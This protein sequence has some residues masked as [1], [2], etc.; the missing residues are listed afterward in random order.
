MKSRKEDAQRMSKATRRKN[1]ISVIN[2]TLRIS[3]KRLKEISKSSDF[4]N[5]VR[6]GRAFNALTYTL[7]LLNIAV[8]HRGAILCPDR[9]GHR[10]TLI[11][12]GYAYES[13]KLLNSLEKV[14][15]SDS[16]FDKANQLLMNKSRWEVVEKLRDMSG[17]HLDHKD[18]LTTK[19]IQA[20]EKKNVDVISYPGLDVGSGP[21]KTVY[22]NLADE[23]DALYFRSIFKKPSLNTPEKV[24]EYVEL[25]VSAILKEVIY[26]L[27]DVLLGL[28]IKLGFSTS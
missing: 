5:L 1:K 17:F 25:E 26:A 20:M 28:S 23:I 8:E 15:S 24:D 9:F 12:A 21:L 18:E 16:F 19:T 13:L 27:R 14:Y 22:F 10:T 4:A 11:A 2:D 7:D 6:V 3:G